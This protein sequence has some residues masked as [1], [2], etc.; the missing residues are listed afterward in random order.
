[1]LFEFHSV[2]MKKIIF[3]LFIST[4]VFASKVDT[5]EVFSRSMQKPIKNIV[6]LPDSY[7]NKNFPVLYLLHG[8]SGDYTNW[9]NNVPELKTYAD[10]YN[11]IIVCPDGDPF[12]WYFDSSINP[13]M[14]YETYIVKELVTEVDKKYNTLTSTKGRAITGLSMGGHGAFYLAFKHQDIFG[15]AGSMS[16]GMNLVKF[17]EYWEID[18]LLGNQNEYPENWKNNTIMYM[19]DLVVG[20]DLKIIFDCGFDDFFYEVN[21][22]LHQKMI[23]ENIPHEYT[24]R[25]GKHDWNYWPNSL[26]YHMVFFD[27]FFNSKL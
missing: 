9:I 25:P 6:I 5:L 16:G 18:Q 20:K 12:S 22:E 19:T 23:E 14:K 2:I 27:S 13:K 11:M 3:F 15:A 17:P 21:K 4:S 10:Q 8:A 7:Q 24:E 26:K 1:M